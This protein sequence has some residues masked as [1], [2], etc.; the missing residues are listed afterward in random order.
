[1]KQ[2]KD[3]KA[4]VRDHPIK[5]GDKVL[6]RRKTTKHNS[7]YDPEAYTVTGVYGTQVEAEREGT[8]MVRDSRKCKKV[9]I[10]SPRSYA[11]AVSQQDR[12]TYQRIQMWEQE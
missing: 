4:I 3:S 11:Q 5:T 9:D 1:M 10:I 2:E 6:L 7:V 8:K 12:S